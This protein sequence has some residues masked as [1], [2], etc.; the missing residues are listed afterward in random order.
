MNTIQETTNEVNQIINE[1]LTVSD[2]VL[3]SAEQ[4]SQYILDNIVNQERIIFAD[5]ASKRNLNFKQSLFRGDI[6]AHISVTNY[7][8]R[9][10]SFYNEYRKKYSIDT[11]CKSTFNKVGE[12]VFVIIYVNYISIDNKPT[13]KFNEDLYHE[14]NHIYQQYREGDR[15]ADAEKYAKISSDIYSDNEIK[16]DIA[17]LLYL[18]N[19]S[20]QDSFVSSVYDYVRHEYYKPNNNNV[21]DEI[22]KNSDAFK[23]ICTLKEL[24]NKIYNDK[25][26]YSDCVLRQH[27]FQRWD[28]F[29][30]MVRNAIHRFEKKFA[31]CVKKCKKD[32]VLYEQNTWTSLHESRNKYDLL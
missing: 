25:E 5:G 2:D 11:D 4:I 29:D 14:L 31:M 7:N 10:N 1:E 17:N 22:I 18:C 26:L 12:R 15:Y 6:N 27:N 19:S 13:A 30:K 23:K 28:R 8:F 21:I 3:K 9:D 24:F 16:S 32:F 20:E